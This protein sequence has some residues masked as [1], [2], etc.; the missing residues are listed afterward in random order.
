M[1]ISDVQMGLTSKKNTKIICAIAS[2]HQDDPKRNGDDL[3]ALEHN[4]N[5]VVAGAAWQSRTM[6][7]SFCFS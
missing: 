4:N 6:H 5:H 2:T 3:S 7:V 1:Q